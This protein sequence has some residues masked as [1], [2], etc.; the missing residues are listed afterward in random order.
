MPAEVVL[1]SPQCSIILYNDTLLRSPSYVLVSDKDEDM[2]VSMGMD[3]A[4]VSATLKH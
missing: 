2:A 1:E 3:T 4:Q